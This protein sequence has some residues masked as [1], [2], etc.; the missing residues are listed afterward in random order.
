MDDDLL[1][2]NAAWQSIPLC[3]Q[4]WLVRFEAVPVQTAQ[5]G[6][7]P[8]GTVIWA[9]G[10]LSDSEYEVMGTWPVQAPATTRWA[11]V[12]DDLHLRGVECIGTV[13]SPDPR[14]V[15][16]ASRMAYPS[17]ISLGASA[18]ARFAARTRPA[19]SRRSGDAGRQR[20]P[21]VRESLR[22]QLVL[23]SEEAAQ[24]LQSRVALAVA[25][26]GPFSNLDAARSFVIANLKRAERNLVPFRTGV[27]APAD[28]RSRHRLPESVG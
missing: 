18:V 4:Y 15:A 23:E 13:V 10:V 2:S 25:R 6:V 5:D 27:R 8:S 3:C 26:H 24:R 20:R 22:Q 21:I 7:A 16:A 19:V 28:S 14:T 12:F 17:A 11:E 1:A 9:F